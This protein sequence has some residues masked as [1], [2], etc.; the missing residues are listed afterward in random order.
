MND[1]DAFITDQASPNG[2]APPAFQQQL[3]PSPL[4]P[5]RNTPPAPRPP[6]M[7]SPRVSAQSASNRRSM[8][9]PQAGFQVRLAQAPKMLGDFFGQSFSNLAVDFENNDI[10]NF[11]LPAGGPIDLTGRLRVSDNNSALPQDRIYL[12]YNYFKNTALLPESVDVSRFAPGFEKT[13]ADGLGSVEIR[14]P[15]A[16]T[17]NSNFEASLPADTSHYEF[18]NLGLI[19][20]LV[21]ISDEDWV[22][23]AGLGI[24]VPTG[25]DLRISLFGVEDTLKIENDSVHLLPYLALAYSPENRSDFAHAFLTFDFDTN[26]NAVFGDQGAGLESIGTWNDQ[27]LV[28]LNLAYGSWLYENRSCRH[29]LQ[30]IA[31]STELHYTA[32]ISDPDVLSSGIYALG[33]PASEL[34]LLNATI[35][36]HVQLGKTTFSAGFVTPLTSSDRVF[37]GE[38]RL[39]VNR[40][41]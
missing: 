41:F 15:M 14:M 30:G 39:F 18:G 32:T 23:A 33:D 1:A 10:S 37:D 20:K 3:P 12:D 4:P 13:F 11:S 35:G 36:G 7:S 34:S 28:T 38:L 31:W 22:I 2:L 21:L 9:T 8:P 29:R 6:G 16:E 27:S 17:L 25:D 24:S 26:G 5:S 19:T 40:A